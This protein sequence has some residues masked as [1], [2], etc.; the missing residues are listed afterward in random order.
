MLEPL[1]TIVDEM[2]VT[3][4]SSDRALDVDDSASLAVDVFG[5]DRVMSP[6]PCL[7][8]SMSQSGWPSRPRTSMSGA[9]MLVTG[10]VITA[11]EARTLLGRRVSDGE[12]ELTPE[13]EE[14]RRAK[15]KRATRGA[16]AA[17]LSSRRSSCC[18]CPGRW[19]SRRWSRH[20]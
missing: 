19:R 16:L 18:S 3:Q 8:R 7:K 6:A 11:G 2:V 10:S 14:F 15:T 13:Q 17:A 20:R 9:G 4:N 1:E 5:A 12:P